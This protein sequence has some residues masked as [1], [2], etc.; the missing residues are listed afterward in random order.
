MTTV[1]RILLAAM[2]MVFVAG[3]WVAF[4]EGSTVLARSRQIESKEARIDSLRAEKLKLGDRTRAVGEE[5]AALPDSIA[6]LR[7][8]Y[9]INQAKKIAKA[10]M[11][12]DDHISREQIRVRRYRKERGEASRRFVSRDLPLGAAFILLGAAYMTVRKRSSTEK[13]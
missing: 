4:R 2:M 10:E 7:T 1:A 9:A 8:G 13:N 5:M 12:I 3:A 6:Q 11:I